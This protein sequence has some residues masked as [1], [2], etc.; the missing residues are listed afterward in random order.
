MGQVHVEHLVGM[1]ARG[2]IELA[3]IGDR[4]GPMLAAAVQ[5][6]TDLGGPDALPQFTTPEEMAAHARLDGVVIASRTE[7]HVRDSLAFVRH[8]VAVL[9]EKPIAN[10]IAEAAEFCDAL[11]EAHQR[12]VQVAFQ[13]HYDAAARKA[14]E[15]L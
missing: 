12:R 14:L 6:I 9:V 10:S 3:A 5:L 15:W 13:R 7:D 1:H 11:G 4:Y 8:G 2:E